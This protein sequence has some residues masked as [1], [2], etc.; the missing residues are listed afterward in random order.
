MA[1]D[2]S[3]EKFG[4]SKN[5]QIAMA[6]IAAIL[7]VVVIVLYNSDNATG[8]QQ[9][10]TLEPAL[11]VVEP[12]DVEEHEVVKVGPEPAPKKS[13]QRNVSLE[14]C[15]INSEA[16]FIKKGQKFRFAIY[17]HEFKF[18]VE[19]GTG[20]CWQKSNKE[21]WTAANDGTLQLRSDGPEHDFVIID[22]E[23]NKDNEV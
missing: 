4:I 19:D 13:D 21:P 3:G 6:V 1:D 8:P 16:G 11:E 5:L 9:A 7:L 10:T 20:K 22:V 14:T 12:I 2:K 18:R 23:E 17:N 15:T